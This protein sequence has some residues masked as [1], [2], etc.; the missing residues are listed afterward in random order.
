MDY[1]ASSR[2]L[3]VHPDQ[4]EA[5]WQAILDFVRADVEGTMAHETRH[6]MTKLCCA[7]VAVKGG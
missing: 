6:D 3:I 2:S 1:F 4:T 7:F 5:E